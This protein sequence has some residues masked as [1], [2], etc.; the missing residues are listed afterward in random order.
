MRQKLD[1]EL[2]QEFLQDFEQKYG[3]G[4]KASYTADQTWELT[5]AND[6]KRHQKIEE[7]RLKHEEG[8][9]GGRRHGS[10]GHHHQ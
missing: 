6:Q 7:R 4:G 8:H 10:P 5:A 9:H 2:K 3:D 1:A